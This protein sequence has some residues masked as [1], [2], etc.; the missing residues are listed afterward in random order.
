[1][2]KL[3]VCQRKGKGSIFKMN[4]KQNSG[5]P[6]Y[7][8][9]NLYEKNNYYKGII[10]K[11]LFDRVCNRPNL[12]IKINAPNFK[13][14]YYELFIAVE[15]LY[16][17]KTIFCGL[18]SK[19]SLGSVLPIKKCPLGSSICNV[20]EKQGDCGTIARASGTFCILTTLLCTKKSAKIKLPSKNLKLIN[21]N[22]RATIGL[23]AGSGRTKKPLLKAGCK[24]YNMMKKKKKFPR[25]RGVATNPV[26]HPHGG[27]NH[28]HVGHSSTVSR[29]SPPGQKV[30]LIAAKR[31]GV[32]GH[33]IF[34]TVKENMKI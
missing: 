34:F 18:K 6:K 11:F 27:G 17:G 21:F 25:I 32:K 3:I 30:G 23:V 20:E 28:Q 31:T 12:K 4:L 10:T 24:F 26:D 9:L 16:T 14:S 19:L 8:S 1:M 22:C 29:R 33:R 7:V 15:G 5:S 2:G 13:F